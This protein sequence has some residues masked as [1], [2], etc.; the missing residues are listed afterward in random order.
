M[1]NE[2]EKRII[3]RKCH[4]HQL[5]N[6]LPLRVRSIHSDIQAEII[7]PQHENYDAFNKPGQI[8]SIE[9]GKEKIIVQVPRFKHNPHLYNH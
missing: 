4:S 1:E 7:F 2:K 3:K 9:C 5:Q 6:S 8:L